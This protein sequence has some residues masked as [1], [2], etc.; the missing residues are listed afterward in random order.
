VPA[1]APLHREP[2]LLINVD[3]RGQLL[4]PSLRADLGT[5]FRLCLII[6]HLLIIK[7]I[8]TRAIICT[9]ARAD[10]R[11]RFRQCQSPKSC[12]LAERRRKAGSGPDVL[13]RVGLASQGVGDAAWLWE[14][15]GGT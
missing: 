12:V 13:S 3:A 5:F 11:R 1:A 6:Y 7:I 15:L 2:H 4:R 8:S 9:L 14:R 10:Q